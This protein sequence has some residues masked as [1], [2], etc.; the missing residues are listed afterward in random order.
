MDTHKN[1]TFYAV[2]A[3]I[4]KGYRPMRQKEVKDPALLVP[5]PNKCVAHISS[6]RQ[7]TEESAL[8]ALVIK[9]RAAGADAF[10]LLIL[11]YSPNNSAHLDTPVLYSGILYVRDS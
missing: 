10:S 5:E 11:S 3:L 7:P 1:N 9:A 4:T 2:N 8:E 6:L